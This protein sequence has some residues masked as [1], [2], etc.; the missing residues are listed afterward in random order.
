MLHSTTIKE[1]IKALK[2][3]LAIQ[4]QQNQVLNKC[5]EKEKELRQQA[6]ASAIAI[7]D[8]LVQKEADIK[9]LLTENKALQQI[10]TPRD[11]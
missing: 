6:R 4:R 5:L 10:L 1:Q 7:A 3:E 9:K 8:K 2:Q 11:E